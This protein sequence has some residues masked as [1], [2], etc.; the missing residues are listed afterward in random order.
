MWVTPGLGSTRSSQ[1]L[2]GMCLRVFS[3]MG[4]Q[5]NWDLLMERIW[6]KQQAQ[7]ARSCR[8]ERAT[9]HGGGDRAVGGHSW[10][11]D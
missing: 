7:V 10:R 9:G 1:E 11:L 5:A 3:A 8:D 2:C 6:R 4:N